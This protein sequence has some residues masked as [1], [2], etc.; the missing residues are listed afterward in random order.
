MRAELD[1]LKYVSKKVSASCDER[2]SVPKKGSVKN[3]ISLL[4][5]GNS[6]YRENIEKFVPL[7]RQVSKIGAA[8]ELHCLLLSQRNFGSLFPCF[9]VLKLTWRTT[10]PT[11][12]VQNALWKT[13][14]FI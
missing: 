11:K 14:Y 8:V 12:F 1:S 6:V 5:A 4:E 3:A 10:Q 7:S 2:Y 13:I 9:R